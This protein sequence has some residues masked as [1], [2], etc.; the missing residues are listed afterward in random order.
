VN[1]KVHCNEQ[2]AD[3][4]SQVFFKALCNLHKYQFKGLPFGSWLYRIAK[5][6]IYQWFRD[7]SKMQTSDFDSLNL[8]KFFESYQE[9]DNEENILK[10]QKCL[11]SLKQ[12]ELK[13]IALRFYDGLSFRDIGELLNVHENNAKVKCF[14]S[15]AKLKK[16]YF[17]LI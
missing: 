5:S 16:L 6:E 15:V 11:K 13:L 17:G 12:D 7:Q 1:Q 9:D 14:R 8:S 10:L 2:S 4:T 3:I